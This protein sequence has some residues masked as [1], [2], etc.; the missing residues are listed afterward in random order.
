MSFPLRLTKSWLI[1]PVRRHRYYNAIIPACQAIENDVTSTLG[2]GGLALATGACDNLC[3]TTKPWSFHFGNQ[4]WHLHPHPVSQQDTQWCSWMFSFTRELLNMPLFFTCAPFNTSML[5]IHHLPPS[6]FFP[7][8]AV[9]DL[10]SCHLPHGFVVVL[11][12]GKELGRASCRPSGGWCMSPGEET[13]HRR[14]ENVEMYARHDAR[15]ARPT[16]H[17]V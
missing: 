17:C 5:N 3:P 4:P 12:G 16:L 9:H 15:W 7:C 2:H 11:R 1:S 13:Q 10:H 8:H 6:S 14:W